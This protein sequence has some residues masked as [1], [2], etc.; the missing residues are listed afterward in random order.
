MRKEHPL[1][2]TCWA[3]GG[4]WRD[5]RFACVGYV[6]S[7]LRP[8]GSHVHL[9]FCHLTAIEKDSKFGGNFNSADVHRE[10]AG[11]VTGVM[12]GVLCVSFLGSVVKVSAMIS[13]SSLALSN[14]FL[15]VS[16]CSD[17]LSSLS[18]TSLNQSVCLVARS[19]PQCNKLVR[20]VRWCC[21]LSTA[22]VRVHTSFMLPSLLRCTSP[23]VHPF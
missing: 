13:I 17:A 3:R 9:K 11:F 12:S 20:S 2:R 5:V 4:M 6:H 1:H 18:S 16:T 7:R 14:A 10:N 22:L 19:A 8:T 23:A 21:L 15:S